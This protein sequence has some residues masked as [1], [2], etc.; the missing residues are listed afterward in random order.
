MKGFSTLPQRFCW[1]RFGTEAGETVGSILARKERERA[2]SGG[3]FLW[4]I[5]NSI[6][7]AVQELVRVENTPQVLFSPMRSKAK[8]IDVSP[9]RLFAWT[10]A[11]T[12]S[13]E[14]WSIPD[15][16][17]VVSR[18]N[19][20]SGEFKSVHY[21]LVCRSVAPL[22]IRDGTAE[23]FFD[24]M[25]NLLSQNKLGHSQVTSVVCHRPGNK[26]TG[27]A[28]AVGLM[29]ELVYPYFVHLHDPEPI[30]AGDQLGGRDAAGR[31]RARY[32]GSLLTAQ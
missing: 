25:E 8:D 3:V 20:A 32:Q 26:G 1:T 17:Q 6:G 22:R 29:A 18:A 16:L 5:G 31:P 10:R 30:Q 24:D 15:G 2:L 14:D 28:Y 11:T 9:S 19:T 23:L 4:G 27:A 13:H 12:A 21:A 7:P